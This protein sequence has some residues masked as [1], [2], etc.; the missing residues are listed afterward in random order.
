M[1]NLLFLD[2]LVLA[3]PAARLDV[4]HP[5][6]P[7]IERRLRG[8]KP[9]DQFHGS[10]VRIPAALRILF[11]SASVSA[12]RASSSDGS[13]SAASRF[14]SFAPSA[15]TASGRWAYSGVR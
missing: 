8:A 5:R 14:P 12:T 9:G 13:G 6:R 10:S 1:K 15:L 11:A 7:H 2:L 4:G 3:V